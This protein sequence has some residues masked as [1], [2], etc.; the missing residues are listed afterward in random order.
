MLLENRR[1]DFAAAAR[2]SGIGLAVLQ[3][4][5]EAEIGRFQTDNMRTSTFSL[6]LPKLFRHG[7]LIA[8]LDS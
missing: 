1:N 2:A 8:S 5:L 4:D 3:R 7:R 6:Y